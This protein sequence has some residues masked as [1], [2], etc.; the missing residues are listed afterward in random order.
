VEGVLANS[1]TGNPDLKPIRGWNLD[2]SLE[3]YVN[4]D[5]SF[6][7]ATYYKWLKGAAFDAHQPLP[8]TIIANG[9]PVTFNAVAPANDPETRH[10][11]G[12]EV[13]GNHA[14]SYL[15]GLLS[16]FGVSGSLA[17]TEADFEF[18]D[19]STVSPYVDPSN[20]IGLSKYTGSGSVYWENDK[21]SLRASYRYRSDY[22]KPNSGS[23]RSVR[24]SG[25][26]NLSASYDLTKQ[27][28]LKLQALNVTNTRD[29]MYKA[30]EDSI[31]EVS[32]NGPQVYFGVR[33]RY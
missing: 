11:Y 24:G 1:T 32:D 12:V 8:T 4:R 6:V 7:I 29:V 10:L 22:F 18:P 14:F 27:V 31:T 13:S 33:F 19:P 25:F 26:L 17:I 28:Q 23:N 2:A 21:L 3:F 5:T 16:G 9:A 30:G 20:L 15:P